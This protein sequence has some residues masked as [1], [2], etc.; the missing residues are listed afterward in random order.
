MQT[1]WVLKIDQIVSTNGRFDIQNIPA[2]TSALIAKVK[3]Q[4]VFGYL[5]RD[6]L[7]HDTVVAREQ[8]VD[9]LEHGL[10]PSEPA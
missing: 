6:I 1:F 5:V 7:Y 4:N 3:L 9:I 8:R 10:I 2:T